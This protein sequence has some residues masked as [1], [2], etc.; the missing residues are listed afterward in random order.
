MKTFGLLIIILVIGLF[1]W[2]NWPTEPLPE[3]LRADRVLV[4]KG[5]RRL[6][7]FRDGTILKQYTVALGRNPIG[8]KEREGD[9]KTPEGSYRI[10]EHKQPSAF[11]LA[12]RL[13]YPETRDIARAATLRAAAGSDIMIH[14]LR[15]GLGGVGKLHRCFDWTAGCIAVT[16]AEIEEIAHAVP[17]GTRVEIRP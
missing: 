4:E 5:A 14:G 10:L 15:N 8:P 1:T 9:K 6:T 17:D 11:H 3:G 7:P 13:S 16:N 12:L 2:S